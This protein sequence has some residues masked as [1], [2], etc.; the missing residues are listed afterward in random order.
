VNDGIFRPQK[1][2]LVRVR[3]LDGNQH[4]LQSVLILVEARKIILYLFVLNGNQVVDEH[5]PKSSE[6]LCCSRNNLHPPF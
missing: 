4:I 3:F 2:P 5:H 6:T 1:L